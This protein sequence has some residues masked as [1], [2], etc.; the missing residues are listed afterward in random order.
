MKDFFLEF[1]ILAPFYITPSI[2][3]DDRFCYETGT[4]CYI[5]YLC[6]LKYRIGLGKYIN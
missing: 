1:D 3:F 4:I 5:M 6:F 2:Y